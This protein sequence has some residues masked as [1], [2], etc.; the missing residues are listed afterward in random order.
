MN[1]AE[2]QEAFDNAFDQSLVFHGFTEYMRDFEMIMQFSAD[3][4]T[5]IPTEH[6]RYIFVHCVQAT[7]S[8]ALPPQAWAASLDE[9]LTDYETGSELDGYVWGVKW[10]ALYPGFEVASQ[11]GVGK[12]W[13]DKVGIPFYEVRVEANGHNFD[14]VFSD[15]RVEPAPPGYSPFVVGTPFWDGKVPLPGA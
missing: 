11:S 9:R 1:L 3:P 12:S 6:F 7:I 5:G 2:M 10:Q 8:T 15:L 13:S 14:L 4:S